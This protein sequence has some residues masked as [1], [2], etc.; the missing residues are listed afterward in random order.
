MKMKK[1]LSTAALGL[2]SALLLS[3]CAKKP[4]YDSPIKYDV[5]TQTT[6]YHRSKAE[7]LGEDHPYL[8]HIHK[9]PKQ[10]VWG[11]IKDRAPTA[12]AKFVV[13]MADNPMDPNADKRY[14]STEQDIFEKMLLA[15]N[16][17]KKKK[18]IQAYKQ[19]LDYRRGLD[20]DTTTLF[21]IGPY[22]N[23][24]VDRELKPSFKWNA[25][26][27]GLA[28]KVNFLQDADIKFRPK[29]I[30]HGEEGNDDHQ[31]GLEWSLRAKF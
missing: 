27:T 29:M 21:G 16:N 31:P 20:V 8:K 18:N 4:E 6:T 22:F 7:V 28:E 26:K 1:Y 10:T 24:E 19:E 11:K 13:S 2:T 30:N 5:K 14:K 12:F 9:D 15:K 25:N 17:P 3:N 23:L